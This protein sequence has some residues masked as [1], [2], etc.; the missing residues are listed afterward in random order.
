MNESVIFI[1]AN[2][3]LF[4]VRGYEQPRFTAG[5]ANDID[6]AISS[7]I[8]G[9]YNV[10]MKSFPDDVTFPVSFDCSLSGTCY[11]RMN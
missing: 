2:Y 1:A 9:Y 7:E 6:F 11:E 8:C 5:I 4:P 10:V 3:D